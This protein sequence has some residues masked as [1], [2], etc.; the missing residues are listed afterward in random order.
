M[1][2]STKV[3]KFAGS[4]CSITPQEHVLFTGK[5]VQK[6]PLQLSSEVKAGAKDTFLDSN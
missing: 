6:C 3:G 1:R 4:I 5:C 2:V